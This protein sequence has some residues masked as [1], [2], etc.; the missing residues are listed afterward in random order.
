MQLDAERKAKQKIM[1]KGASPLRT[2]LTSLQDEAIK[3]GVKG[4]KSPEFGK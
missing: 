4:V 1:I 3:A 2:S